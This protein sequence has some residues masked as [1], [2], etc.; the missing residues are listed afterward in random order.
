MSGLDRV[1]SW[2]LVRLRRHGAVDSAAFRIVKVGNVGRTIREKLVDP[3]LIRMPK[4]LCGNAQRPKRYA[5]ETR[6]C[7]VSMEVGGGA[8]ATRR[9]AAARTGIHR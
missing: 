8:L 1:E 6:E 3:T 5:R 7:E 9:Y 4:T 2:Y